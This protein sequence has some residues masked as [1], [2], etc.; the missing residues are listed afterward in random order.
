M[1]DKVFCCLPRLNFTANVEIGHSQLKTY[2]LRVQ[3]HE[4]KNI[5]WMDMGGWQ[6][7]DPYVVVKLFDDFELAKAAENLLHKRHVNGV[8]TNIVNGR[9]EEDASIVSPPLAGNVWK[10]RIIED[11]MAPKWA[12]DAKRTRESRWVRTEDGC[13]MVGMRLSACVMIELWDCDYGK[14]SSTDELIG[15]IVLKAADFRTVQGRLSPEPLEATVPKGEQMHFSADYIVIGCS[16]STW[17][18]SVLTALCL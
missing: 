2:Q 8:A 7:S 15:T 14:E 10:S 11:S 12:A 18:V 9:E 1:H 4:A 3:I 6:P 5:P 16:C 13:K 17:F